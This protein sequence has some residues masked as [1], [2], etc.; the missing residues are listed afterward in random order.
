[1][2]TPELSPYLPPAHREQLTE[3]VK[4]LA[5]ATAAAGQTER[6]EPL[7]GIPGGISYVAWCHGQSIDKTWPYF[8]LRVM[9]LPVATLAD[10]YVQC[11]RLRTGD[12][13]KLF[14]SP[15]PVV[16]Y[17]VTHVSAKGSPVV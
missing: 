7:E 8:R 1:M 13:D 3:A 17:A 16:R 4:R 2:N 12:F 11:E 15:A 5:R 10:A 9:V 6:C 14:L